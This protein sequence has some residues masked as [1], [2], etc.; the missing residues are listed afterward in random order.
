MARNRQETHT[1][2]QNKIDS[3]MSYVLLQYTRLLVYL[4]DL[5]VPYSFLNSLTKERTFT[6]RKDMVN[7]A[8]YNGNV[9]KQSNIMIHLI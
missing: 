8:H 9:A 4:T 1:R 6:L 5:F 2:I 7:V 3:T